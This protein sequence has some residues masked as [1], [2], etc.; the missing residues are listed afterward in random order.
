MNSRHNHVTTA[1]PWDSQ[2][3][4]I[5]LTVREVNGLPDLKLTAWTRYEVGEVEHK[6]SEST[7]TSMS[8]KIVLLTIAKLSYYVRV[9]YMTVHLPLRLFNAQ[10]R[11]CVAT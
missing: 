11:R 2:S 1:Q 4:P 6:N 5:F 10:K 3:G 7:R 9:R 8:V